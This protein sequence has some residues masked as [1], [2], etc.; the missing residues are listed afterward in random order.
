M[1]RVL[2]CVLVIGFALASNGYA[3]IEVG[4]AGF[5]DAPTP[6]NWTDVLTPWQTLNEA[7]GWAA[8]IT[9]NYYEGEPPGVPAIYTTEDHVWQVL[10]AAFVQGE[11]YEFSID[12]GM[13]DWGADYDNFAWEIYIFDAT[14][15]TYETHLS[16]QSGT[17][18]IAA[19]NAGTWERVSVEYV[20][21]SAEAGHNIGIGFTG[22]YY[23]MYDNASV[24]PEPATMC[25]LGIGVLMLRRRRA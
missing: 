9:N 6:D 23:T 2:I 17:L 24:V 1:K 11:T 19:G 8:W 3:A 5:D 15:A 18:T 22:S 13:P 7:G 16:T 12:A 14:A 25:L 10:S 20:A 21:T 4:N